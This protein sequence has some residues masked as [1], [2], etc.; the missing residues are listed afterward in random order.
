M[1]NCVSEERSYRY[2]RFNISHMSPNGLVQSCPVLICMPHRGSISGKR[3]RE[4]VKVLLKKDHVLKRIMAKT[5]NGDPV[6]D[7]FSGVYFSD[8]HGNEYRY[9]EV[10]DTR[11]ATITDYDR[12]YYCKDKV[13][14]IIVEPEWKS[15]EDAS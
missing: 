1:G 2:F 4:V 5:A 15:V 3:L 7:V 12:I 9:N 14:V 13:P 11:I 8:V 6:V 10:C